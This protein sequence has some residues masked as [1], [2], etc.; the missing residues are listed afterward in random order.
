MGQVREETIAV[1]G[2]AEDPWPVTVRR[3]GDEPT[4]W[5]H[6]VPTC[7][8]DW[9]PF[10]ERFGGIAPDLPGFGTSSK[11]GDG[12]FTLA[13]YA[14]FV[15]ALVD[16]LGL[17]QVQLV[18]HDWGAAALAWAALHPERIS[19]L[20][21]MNAVPLLGGYRWHRVARGWRTPGLGETMMGLTSGWTLRR[22]LPPEVGSIAAA[23]FDQGTQRAILRLYR[24]ASGDV[25]ASHEGALRS[26]S[27]VPALVLWG[28]E[29]RYISAKFARRYAEALGDP[30]V[31]LVPGAGHW[32]WVDDPE[33]VDTI[34]RFLR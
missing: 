20:V 13:G 26:L 32:P 12:D 1:G 16:G 28:E 8:A 6:G 24:S 33:V 21:V 31:Q 19:R 23:H 14:R 2:W 29:D 30:E 17:E 15:G 18:V 7:G 9:T 25:L 11:R 10:L 22:A 3:A 34:G 4:L 27:G 5:V